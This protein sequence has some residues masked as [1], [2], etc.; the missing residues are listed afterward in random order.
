MIKP[1]ACYFFGTG[2]QKPINHPTDIIRHL[3]PE[4]RHHYRDGYSMA[5]AA[6]CWMAAH[7][8]LPLRIAELVGN[9]T[10]ETAHFEYGEKVWGGGTSMT[11][12]MA[13][14]PDSVIAVEAKYRESFDD[15]VRNWIYKEAAKNLRSPPHR[16]GVIGQYGRALGVPAEALL[17][18]RYQLLHRTLASARV[19]RQRGRSRA[20]MIVH[21]FAPSQCEEHAR[22]RADFDRYVSLIG[23]TPVL[24]GIP[25]RLAWSDEAI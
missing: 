1:E 17:V 21:S 20:W 13:F 10:L 24:E 3:P 25:V 9:D 19:A 7:G 4:R 5:E 14:I 22:N 16:L 18:L 12:I 15:E 11:D 8:Q 6:K 23:T 2:T